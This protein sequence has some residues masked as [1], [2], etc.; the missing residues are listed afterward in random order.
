[1]TADIIA[2]FLCE[3]ASRWCEVNCGSSQLGDGFRNNKTTRD[4]WRGAKISVG[5]AT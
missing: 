4:L 2:V 5:V 1:M 3:S